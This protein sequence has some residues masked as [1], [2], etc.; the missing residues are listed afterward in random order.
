MI[1]KEL[2]AGSYKNY[3]YHIYGKYTEDYPTE[4]DGE[5]VYKESIET[6]VKIMNPLGDIVD[7]YSWFDNLMHNY[8]ESYRYLIRFRQVYKK[9]RGIKGLYYEL[10]PRL[11]EVI[12]IEDD[13]QR[14][15]NDWTNYCERKIDGMVSEREKELYEQEM[16]DGLPDSVF[17]KYLD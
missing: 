9:G 15:L 14:V 16:T 12:H 5:V 10:F 6:S 13:Y 11:E 2:K 1:W 4:I 8:N 17:I 3:G 7:E